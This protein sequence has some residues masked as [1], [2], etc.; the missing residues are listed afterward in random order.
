MSKRDE[1]FLLQ[2]IA[3]AGTKVLQF[4]EGMNFKQFMEDEKTQDACITNFEPRLENNTFVKHKC[5]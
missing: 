3:I 2:N 5:L 1:L 4:T